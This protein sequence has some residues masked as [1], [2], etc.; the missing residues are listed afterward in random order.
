MGLALAR[1]SMRLFTIYTKLK[2][3]VSL[4]SNNS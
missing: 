2:I 3:V 1:E 4:Q